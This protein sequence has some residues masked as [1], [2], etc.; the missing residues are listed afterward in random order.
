MDGAC[1][2]DLRMTDEVAMSNYFFLVNKAFARLAGA[3]LDQINHTADVIIHELMTTQ[4]H[5]YSLNVQLAGDRSWGLG[6][7]PSLII[8]KKHH[9]DYLRSMHGASSQEVLHEAERI[10]HHVKKAVSRAYCFTGSP[11]CGSHFVSAF[12]RGN[13]LDIGHE[14]VGRD[15][16]CA[17]QFAVSSHNYP[18]VSDRQARSDFF[19]QA[20]NWFVYARSP[21]TAIPSLIVENQ[22]APLS[23]A[24]RREAIHMSA[25]VNLDDFISPE[26]RAAR[27][28]AHWYLLALKRQP[29]GVL[30]V[31]EF[32]EDCRLNIR[33][34]D[35][36]PVEILAPEAGAGKSYLGIIHKPEVLE[37]GWMNRLSKE[38]FL[39]LKHVSGNLG[40]QI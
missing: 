31:E 2:V 33:N 19:V 14:S 6:D 39:V 3:R 16:I 5:C 4:A 9:L 32:L 40:Y 18:Y 20:D 28:Y 17:W 21:L 35:F 11:R 34:H 26:E 8:P 13:G 27:S 15:G 10:S 30:R 7:I 37:H 29:K 23:Y 38:T 24:F 12:L 22:R 1:D 36:K 25:G